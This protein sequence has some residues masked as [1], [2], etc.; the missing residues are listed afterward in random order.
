MILIN[1]HH[2]I[3]VNIKKLLINTKKRKREKLNNNWIVNIKFNFYSLCFKLKA[4]KKCN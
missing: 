2:K 1:F 4:I 3:I